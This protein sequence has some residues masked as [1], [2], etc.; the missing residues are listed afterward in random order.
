MS[1]ILPVVLDE[2]HKSI[3]DILNE[4][5]PAVCALPKKCVDHMAGIIMEEPPQSHQV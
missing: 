1:L 4:F 3:L 5:I 2:S